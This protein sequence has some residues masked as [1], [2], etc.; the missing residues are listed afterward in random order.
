MMKN[1]CASD[2]HLS[3]VCPIGRAGE[4]AILLVATTITRKLHNNLHLPAAF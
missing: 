4:Y 2:I 1:D 3:D